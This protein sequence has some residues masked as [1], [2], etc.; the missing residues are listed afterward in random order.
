MLCCLCVLPVHQVIKL[1]AHH[2]LQHDEA[3]LRSWGDACWRPMSHLYLRLHAQPCVGAHAHQ[4][5]SLACDQLLDA[6]RDLEG[7]AE[8]LGLLE[9]GPGEGGAGRERVLRRVGGGC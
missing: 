6:A 5:G 2:F 3:L 8:S 4:P 1:L 7:F 9:G